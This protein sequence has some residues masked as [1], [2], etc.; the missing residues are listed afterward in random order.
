MLSFISV[1]LC[2]GVFRNRQNRS[3]EALYFTAAANDPNNPV[4]WDNQNNQLIVIITVGYTTPGRARYERCYRYM[5][6]L[7]RIY[8]YPCKSR[9]I[10]VIK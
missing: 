7:T 4:L 9:Q 3:D 8:I 6:T 1:T 2:L 5:I 10:R